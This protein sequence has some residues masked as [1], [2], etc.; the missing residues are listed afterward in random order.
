MDNQDIRQSGESRDMTGAEIMYA[1]GER[2]GLNGLNM[3]STSADYHKGWLDGRRKRIEDRLRMPA[4]PP[5]ETLYG[6]IIQRSEDIK[7]G[8][9]DDDEEGCY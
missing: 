8:R 1:R 2:D 9:I 4:L 5:R 7:A 6:M 3:S